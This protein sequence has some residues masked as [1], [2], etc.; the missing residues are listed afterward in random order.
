MPPFGGR[1]A[2]VDGTLFWPYKRCPLQDPE[3]FVFMVTA[4]IAMITRVPTET[5]K[6]LRRDFG[7]SHVLSRCLVCMDGRHMHKGCGAIRSAAVL[8]SSRCSAVSSFICSSILPHVPFRAPQPALQPPDTHHQRF[9]VRFRYGL[10]PSS[11]SRRY[12][13]GHRC[14]AVRM[15]PDSC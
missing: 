7:V 15:R 12:L 1:L 9:A 3:P 8:A 2:A 13:V 4:S 11:S 10:P 14:C 6:A 5:G